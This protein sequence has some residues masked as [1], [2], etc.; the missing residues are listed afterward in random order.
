MGVFLH[1]SPAVCEEELFLLGVVLQS[2]KPAS[3]LS[4]F[5]MAEAVHFFLYCTL[6]LAL[7]YVFVQL[8]AAVIIT[9]DNNSLVFESADASFTPKPPT[10]GICGTLFVGNPLS[11][12]APLN[13]VFTAT[14][15]VSCSEFVLFSRGG[16]SFDI[17]VRHAQDAGF[18]AVLVSDNLENTEL[19]TMAGNKRGVAIPAVFISKVAGDVLTQ[20]T[21]DSFAECWI[22]PSYENIAWLVMVISFI[23]LIA[24]TAIFAICFLIRQ[25]RRSQLQS[26]RLKDSQGISYQTVKC[27][28]TIVYD[29]RCERGGS[30]DVCAVCLEDYTD[31]AVLRMLPCNHRFH[32]SCIDAWLINWR[33]FCPI[34]KR[35]VVNA[36]S[37]TESTPLLLGLNNSQQQQQPVTPSPQEGSP[38][39]QQACVV[40]IDTRSPNTSRQHVEGCRFSFSRPPLRSSGTPIRAP[41]P[42]RH[43]SLNSLTDPDSMEAFRASPYFTPP[44][45]FRSSAPNVLSSLESTGDSDRIGSL[46]GSLDEA[47]QGGRSRIATRIPRELRDQTVFARRE[48]RSRIATRIPR[49]LRD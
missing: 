16:C 9:K 25:Q 44:S 6:Y 49:E 8:E 45:S 14:E 40:A 24:I 2:W 32:C 29:S 35:D 38:F 19:V 27:L 28:P 3:Q 13:N 47:P 48:R 11:G 36:P 22:L 5:L 26:R 33:S 46:P 18:Q 31:G 39:T 41:R 34:C 10:S 43:L 42:S 37:S 21:N 7:V 30:Y 23:S 1:I 12:C 17:K 20:Y 4:L 15:S